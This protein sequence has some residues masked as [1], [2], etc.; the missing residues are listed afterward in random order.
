MSAPILAALQS[1][2]THYLLEGVGEA[3]LA[4]HVAAP[5]RQVAG[6]RLDVYRHAYY[7]RLEEALAQDFSAVLATLGDREFGRQAA[8]FLSREPSTHPSVRWLGER[9]PAWLRNAHG[10][11]LGDLARLEW[12]VLNASDAEDAASLDPIELQALAPQSWSD[13]R[14]ALH[15]SLTLLEV[16]ANVRE[17]WLALRRSTPAPELA[18]VPE[19][20]AVWRAQPG[21][22]VEPIDDSSLRLLRIL[23]GSSNLGAACERL[24]RDLPPAEVPAVVAEVLCRASMRGWLCRTSSALMGGRE[25]A[26]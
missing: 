24:A 25:P 17:I 5:T 10:E 2:F 4:L 1:S 14:L 26:T 15:P 16:C 11:P 8:S 19:R 12:A 6:T 18:P 13:L 23:A 21:P 7:F 9:F 20:L 22:Q 3:E